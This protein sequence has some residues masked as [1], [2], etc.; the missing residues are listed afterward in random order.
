M[1]LYKGEKMSVPLCP[2]IVTLDGLPLFVLTAGKGRLPLVILHGFASSA[3]T[4][5]RIIRALAKDRLVLAYDRPGFGLTRVPVDH[6]RGLDPYAPSAQVSIA[7]ALLDH[8]GFE[9]C[10]VLGHSMGGGLAADLART[11]PERV[12]SVIL[13]APAWQ[14][15][16]APILAPLA[17]TSVAS[18]L[19]RSLL[20]LLAPL[21]LRLA[22]R[23]IWAGPPPASGETQSVLAASVIGWETAL[24]N[25]TTATLAEPHVTPP[26][27]LTVPTL[28]VFGEQDR[29]VPPSQTLRLVEEWRRHGCVVQVERFERSGHLP[30][31]EEFERFVSVVSRFLTE[32]ERGATPSG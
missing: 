30:H 21:A 28:V 14:R 22:Q 23:A 27:Q 4:W 29:I 20:R 16:S 12:G 1:I 7:L 5:E 8:L 32:V 15:P 25:V 3:L 26:E 19:G 9:R 6:W 2:A 24:W 18:A 10:H 17:R 11:A 31:I 13:V